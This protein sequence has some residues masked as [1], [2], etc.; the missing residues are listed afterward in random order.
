M[1]ATGQATLPG[2][3]QQSGCFGLPPSLR[4][5]LILASLDAQ[6]GFP[7]SCVGNAD[8]HS[9]EGR[10]P[11]QGDC[12][13]MTSQVNDSSPCLMSLTLEVIIRIPLPFLPPLFLWAFAL[14]TQL[15]AST[16]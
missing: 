3:D 14:P 15:C 8:A 13:M 10:S 12:L 5:A 1:P 2:A 6:L 11:Q 16:A 4:C 9:W 7:H